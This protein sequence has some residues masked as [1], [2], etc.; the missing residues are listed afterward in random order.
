MSADY[1]EENP[2]YF[3][4]DATEIFKH[5]ELTRDEAPEMFEMVKGILGQKMANLSTT[6]R[7]SYKRI[8]LYDEQK[9]VLVEDLIKL[10]CEGTLR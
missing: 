3:N 7:L 1:C 9:Q 2:D 6:H 8:E 5:A 10:K 4:T